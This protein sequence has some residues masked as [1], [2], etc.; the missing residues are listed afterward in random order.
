MGLGGQ[1]FVWVKAV[2]YF[3]YKIK[4]LVALFKVDLAKIE[5]IRDYEVVLLKH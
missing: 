3:I 5:Y 4:I 2:F 1:K